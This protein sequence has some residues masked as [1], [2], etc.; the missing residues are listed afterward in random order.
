MRVTV[1]QLKEMKQRGEKIPM[2]T[3][4]DYA[5]AKL[6]DEAGIGALLAQPAQGASKERHGLFPSDSAARLPS[7]SEG[8][9]CRAVR[10]S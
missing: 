2:L 6:V 3:A 4:Y 7:V 8:E 10:A 9:I 1:G 5:T